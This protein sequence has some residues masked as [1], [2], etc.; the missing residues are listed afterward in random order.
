MTVKIKYPNKNIPNSDTK[1]K[2]LEEKL[3]SEQ[4]KNQVSVMGL[5]EVNNRLRELEAKK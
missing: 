1:I 2:E 4:Q 3:K 5:I